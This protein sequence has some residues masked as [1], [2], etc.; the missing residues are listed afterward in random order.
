MPTLVALS[1]FSIPGQMVTNKA[2]K[3]RTKFEVC[4]PSAGFFLGLGGRKNSAHP[5]TGQQDDCFSKRRE[6]F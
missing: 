2:Y 1:C 4:W 3:K 6:R 5:P